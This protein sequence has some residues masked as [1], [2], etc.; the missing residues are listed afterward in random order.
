MGTQP[1]S[2]E[3]G[4]PSYEAVKLCCKEIRFIYQLLRRALSHRHGMQFDALESFTIYTGESGL[5]CEFGHVWKCMFRP[6]F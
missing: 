4:R 5:H 3:H 2:P 6:N 1:E